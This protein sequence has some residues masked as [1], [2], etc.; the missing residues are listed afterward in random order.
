MI[1]LTYVVVIRCG[2]KRSQVLGTTENLHKVLLHLLNIWM[3]KHV[4][5]EINKTTI[6]D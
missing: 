1:M 6:K 2:Y 3:I 4:P 5:C